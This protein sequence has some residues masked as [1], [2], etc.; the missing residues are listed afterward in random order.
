VRGL[1]AKIRLIVA[2]RKLKIKPTRM[3]FQNIK[4][5]TGLSPFVKSIMVFEHD[6]D[7]TKTNLPFMADGFTGLMFHETPNGLF[8]NPHNKKMSQLFVYGQTI[9]PIEMKIHG[10]YQIIVFQLFPFTLKSLFN[11]EPKS[12]N[13]NYHDLTKDSTQ[14]E[15]GTLSALSNTKDINKRISIISTYINKLIAAKR[16]NFD[17]QI[18]AAIKLILLA[19]GKCNLTETAIQVHLNKQTFEE[20]FVSETGLLP[21]QFARMI[22]FENSLTQL[23]VNELTS[24]ADVMYKN[25]FADHFHYIRVFKSFMGRTSKKYPPYHVLSTDSP[26]LVRFTSSLASGGVLHQR[27]Y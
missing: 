19:K 10:T 25:G 7:D 4:F 6:R 22:Q 11:I 9:K 18:R 20:R 27:I 12:I 14:I 3:K 1:F 13:D 2:D 24:F 17:N 15:N 21:K 8:V 16:N 23:S 5:G 26:H